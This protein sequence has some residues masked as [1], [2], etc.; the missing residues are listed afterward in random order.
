M[1]NKKKF[2]FW[3]VSCITSITVS[4]LYLFKLICLFFG[5][6]YLYEDNKILLSFEVS[7]LFIAIIIIIIFFYKE[8]KE[9]IRDEE[10][11]QE[12]KYLRRLDPC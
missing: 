10:I 2:V 8:W 1:L 7:Y 9:L 4:S 11:H 6:I 3:F 12:R 5:R